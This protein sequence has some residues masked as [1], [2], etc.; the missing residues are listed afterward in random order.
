MAF[1]IR[2]AGGSLWWGLWLTHQGACNRQVTTFDVQHKMLQKQGNSNAGHHQSLCREI[3]SANLTA[4]YIRISA[5]ITSEGP[6][7]A[8]PPY[9]VDQVLLRKA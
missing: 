4:L 9:F 6:S 2:V 7:S 1:E 5:T 8:K 3:A